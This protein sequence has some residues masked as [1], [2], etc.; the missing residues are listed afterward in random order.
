MKNAL[1]LTSLVAL[2]F[3]FASCEKTAD[4]TE[5]VAVVINSPTEGST[6]HNGDNLN[7]N[8][9]FTDP[10]ELHNYSVKVMNETDST[11]VLDVSGHSHTTTYTVD[12]TITLSVSAHSDFK[13]IATATNHASESATKDAHFHVH[14]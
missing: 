2:M 4:P 14:P 7:V 3:G 6:M 5:T 10:T 1:I 11:T 9:T 8:V 12:T 13:V